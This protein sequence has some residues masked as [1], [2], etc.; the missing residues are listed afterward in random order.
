MQ[1]AEINGKH[2]GSSTT[3][4]PCRRGL[5]KQLLLTEQGE[6]GKGRLKGTPLWVDREIGSIG[7]AGVR[8]NPQRTGFTWN[9]QTAPQGLSGA[10]V[11]D[12]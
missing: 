11:S 10:R 4:L 6:G 5:L 1:E 7:R 12:M 8:P 9:V 3:L 2:A